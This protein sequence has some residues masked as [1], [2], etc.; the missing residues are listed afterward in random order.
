MK[1]IVVGI[2]TTVLS[3]SL[4]FVANATPVVTFDGSGS[5]TATVADLGALAASATYSDGKTLDANPYAFGTSYGQNATYLTNYRAGNDGVTTVGYGT[6]THSNGRWQGLGFETNE[7]DGVYWKVGDGAW[8]NTDT[9]LTVGDEV[10]FAFL[11]WQANNGNHPYDQLLAGFL[12]KDDLANPNTLFYAKVDT[13]RTSAVW[14]D[15]TAVQYD[16]GVDSDGVKEK[17]NDLSQ[18][19]FLLFETTLT[20]TDGMVGENLLRARVAC[21]HPSDQIGFPK[22]DYTEWAQQGETEDYLFNVEPVPE[23]ATMLL[24]GTGIAGLAGARLRR[25]K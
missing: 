5:S 4:C 22:L 10:T 20:I 3:L 8:G 11:F 2:S 17:D 7:D 12:T 6:P 18:A 13:T 16:Y 23:P 21:H 25:K 19:R 14:S 9:T 1:S 15:T 24:F